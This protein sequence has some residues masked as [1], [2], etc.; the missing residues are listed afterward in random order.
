[1]SFLL[2]TLSHANL[3]QE[4]PSYSYVLTEFN[5]PEYYID[6]PE[7]KAFVNEHKRDY[8]KRFIKAVERGS[9]I[10]P[11]MKE[12]MY[13]RDISPIFIY[14][15]MVES[16]FKPTARSHT[17][18]GG[19]WQITV[20]TAKELKLSVN[21]TIDERYDPIRSTNAAVKY[22][23]R[24]NNDLNSWYLTTMAYNC[25]NGC[26][27]KSIKR[28]GSRDLGVLISSKNSYIKLETK[29]YIKKVLLMAMIGEN[30]LFKNN[31]RVGEL[32]YKMNPDAITPV[33]VRA[34][35]TLTQLALVLNMN[36]SYLEKINAHLKR[37]HVPHNRA[38]SINIPSSKVQM[39]QTRYTSIQREK[40]NAQYA[41]YA[42]YRQ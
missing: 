34:G 21:S 42:Q 14:I 38:Y 9:L 26:V 35:E 22:L 15:S 19:L 5:V 1:L 25:G 12:M 8:K 18:A 20:N 11:M 37:G 30:Y 40:R 3:R 31:D 27:N 41:Q 23:Y 4:F 2:S 36:K 6:N 10:V 24:I 7:F 16:A 29:K 17:G 28:A 33:K 32:M 39:F 13:E